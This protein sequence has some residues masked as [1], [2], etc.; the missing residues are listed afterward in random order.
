MML[1]S[2]KESQEVE[3]TEDNLGIRRKNPLSLDNILP[4][5]KKVKTEAELAVEGIKNLNPLVLLITGEQGE[6]KWRDLQ[7]AFTE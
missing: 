5:L 6:L 7:N 3:A 1:D 4:V 2:V